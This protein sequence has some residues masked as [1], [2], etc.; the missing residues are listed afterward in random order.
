LRKRC[1]RQKN[2][3]RGKYNRFNDGLPLDE[4]APLY[5]KYPN[6]TVEFKFVSHFKGGDKNY[7]DKNG[8]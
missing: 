2:I 6:I 1:K 7:V 5:I 8:K 3:Y 4:I